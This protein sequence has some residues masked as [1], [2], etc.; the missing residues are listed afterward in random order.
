MTAMGNVTCAVF[1]AIGVSF[2]L[3]ADN[4]QW[5]GAVALLSTAKGIFTHDELCKELG[6]EI[7]GEPEIK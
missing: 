4:I 5:A 6:E 3:I 1:L 2:T 7:L